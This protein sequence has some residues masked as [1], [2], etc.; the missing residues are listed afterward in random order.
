MRAADRPAVGREDELAAAVEFL[1]AIAAGPAALLI[2]GDAGIGKTTVWR[3]AVTAAIARGPPGALRDRDRRRGRPAVRHVARPA[4]RRPRRG[5]GGAARRA[6]PRPRGR[7]VPGRRSGRRSADRPT[8]RLGR[9]AGRGPL[10][11]GAAAPGDRRRRR[12]VDRPVVGAGAEL[13]RTEADDRAGRRSGRPPPDRPAVGSPRALGVAAAR[14]PAPD[15][16]GPALRGPDADAA[17][18]DRRSAAAAPA[19][20]RGA[21]GRG[22]QPVLRPGD[23]PRGDARGHAGARRG[24]P[25]AARRAADGDGQ[26]GRCAPW[27]GPAG[28]GRGRRAAQPDGRADHRGGRAGHRGRDR[29]GRGRGPPDDHHGRGH[30]PAPVA[31]DRRGGHAHPGRARRA[32]PQ[33]GRGRRRSRRAG[34]APRRRRDRPRRGHRARVGRC[35]GPRHGPR[36]PRRGGGAGRPGRRAHPAGLAAAGRPDR[37][38][39]RVPLPRGG[40]GRCRGRA[41]RRARPPARGRTPRGGAAV[42]VLRP[43]GPEPHGRRR[44]PRHARPRRRPGAPAARGDRA[45]PRLRARHR[46]G[47]RDRRP[48]R[49]GRAGDGAR[50]RRS[51]LDRRERGHVRVDPVLDRPRAASGAAGG[52]KGPHELDALHSTRRGPERRGRD[53]A[54]LVGPDRRRTRRTAGGGRAA[55]RARPRPATAAH[56]VHPR[57]AGLPHRET[58]T[59]R[60]ASRRRACASP[61]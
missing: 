42:A 60:S 55:G 51:R 27:P 30:V 11:G 59:R 29:G 20:P 49:H 4:R 13:R 53:A 45:R 25:A 37:P 58:G 44:R 2:E 50:G 22:G 15:D 56:A 16:A 48:L 54:D 23:R 10:A 31:A 32:A 26:A 33:S 47:P 3:A 61:S 39:G 19:R 21:P 5:H 17:H 28:V 18:R 43:P 7:P 8:R 1:D 34:R 36:C 57:R 41:G 24:R 14:S 9:R 6:A 35:G 52:D 40:R 46:G 12:R 38:H